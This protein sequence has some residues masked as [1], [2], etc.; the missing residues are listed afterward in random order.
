VTPA[1]PVVLASVMAVVLAV[2]IAAGLGPAARAG[3]TSL[4][5]GLR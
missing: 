3:R 5:S 2:A 1:H 4:V